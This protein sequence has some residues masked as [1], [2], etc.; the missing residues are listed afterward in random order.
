MTASRR[1]IKLS[2]HSQLAGN[3]EIMHG[4]KNYQIIKNQWLFWIFPSAFQAKTP[5][6]LQQ[7]P[8]TLSLMNTVNLGV[9]NNVRHGHCA[10]MS[11]EAKNVHWTWLVFTTLH[12]STQI[13][14]PGDKGCFLVWD[15]YCKNSYWWSW[16]V[17]DTQ[18]KHSLHFYPEVHLR[19]KCIHCSYFCSPHQLD[20]DFHFHSSIKKVYLGRR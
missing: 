13:G 12:Y 15:N 10:K 19:E 5:S 2:A 18:G 3:L 14:E 11:D 20:K 17:W 6:H 1:P 7:K 4:W 16:L 9:Y 8:K